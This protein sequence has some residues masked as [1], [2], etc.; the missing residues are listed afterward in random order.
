M[1]KATLAVVVVVALFALLIRWAEPGLAF[2]PVAGETVTPD[3]FNVQYDALDVDTADGERLRAWRIHH[4]APR[5][6]V[7]YFHGNGG[8]LSM[9][10]P[11][12][13]AIARHGYSV[14][15][16]DY[17]GYGR[18]SGR[19][20]EQGLYRDV[21]AVVKR[22]HAEAPGG[23]PT[24]HWGRSLGASMAAY[25]ATLQPPDGVIIEAGFPDVRA[26][27]RG[28]PVLGLLAPFS[29][30]RFPA[31]EFLQRRKAPVL[32]MHG[33]RD[34]I[35]PFAQGQAL[36]DR[37]PGPKRFVVIPGGDHNDVSAPDAE[38]YWRAIDEFVAGL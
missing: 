29:S 33:D 26:L 12:V 18:S 3:Q 17:R 6:H 9:W 4:P 35:I 11:I 27:L 20:S 30:Y 32:V 1:L 34:S 16:F 37:I 19:P 7:L 13:S 38:A 25:A 5:A 23:T 21:E 36:F 28:T 22:F 15:A 2:F 14:L 10:A 8:N 24:V 31:A